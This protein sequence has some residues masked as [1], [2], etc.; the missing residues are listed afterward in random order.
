MIKNFLLSGVSENSKTIL[1]KTLSSESRSSCSSSNLSQRKKRQ[2][3]KP[4]EDRL[5][6]QLI[7][8]HGQ[9]WK[10]ISKAM[11]NRTGKQI[12]DRYM[13]VL[14]P[15][16]KK[17]YWTVQEDELILSLYQEHGS[18][19]RQIAR[20]LQGRAESQIKNRFHTY[21]KGIYKRRSL[22]KKA[23]DSEIVINKS[24]LSTINV[25]ETSSTCEE[26]PKSCNSFETNGKAADFVDMVF[27]LS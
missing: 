23:T 3:W 24:P 21:L 13:N 15:D 16:I 4:D 10:E 25:F 19:W 6:I 27:S 12:R 14:M 22:T 2:T 1:K 7:G 18:K 11:N 8:K 9:K 20:E 26:S 5:V 17:S